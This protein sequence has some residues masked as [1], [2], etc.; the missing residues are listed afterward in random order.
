MDFGRISQA[1]CRHRPWRDFGDPAKVQSNPQRHQIYFG[2]TEHQPASNFS[3][4]EPGKQA[5]LL[6]CRF[7]GEDRAQ[8]NGRCRDECLNKQRSHMSLRG[9]T[10]NPFATRFIW[11]RPLSH[12]D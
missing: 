5:L 3:R 6:G 4:G 12:S 9:L 10:P 2:L 8:R 1:R 11:V 7:S